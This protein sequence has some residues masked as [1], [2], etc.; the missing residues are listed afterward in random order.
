[1]RHR[2]PSGP[3][4]TDENRP[5]WPG[6][7]SAAG[8]GSNPLCR[9]ETA[10]PP[11]QNT[12]AHRHSATRHHLS[13]CPASAPV[14]SPASPHPNS[15]ALVIEPLATMVEHSRASRAA[16]RAWPAT[17]ARKCGPAWP[18]RGLGPA[19]AD[20]KPS[21][22]VPPDTFPEDEPDVLY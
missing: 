9:N 12:F 2:W 17:V 10:V 13:A 11:G 1:M 18:S 21:W 19:W 15:Q 7:R 16:P 6:E 3:P 4:P 14:H 22:A 5:G 20:Q 8:T